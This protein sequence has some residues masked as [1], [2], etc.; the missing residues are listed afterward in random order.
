[1]YEMPKFNYRLNDLEPYI[2]YRT[3]NMQEQLM[4]NYLD[5][6]NRLL[7]KNNYDFKYSVDDLINHI[8]DFYI[9][10][11]DDILF[12][13][14]G[15]LNHKNYF[16]SISPYNK[17]VLNNE[18]GNAIN[19]KYKTFS[20]FKNIFTTTALNLV[21][22]GYTHLVIDNN[23]NLNIINTINEDTPYEYNLIPLITLDLWEHAYILNNGLNKR[24]YINTFF[25][26]ID[27]NKINDRYKNI[28]N[29][30]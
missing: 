8:D 7:I 17:N 14:G 3:L 20:N 30:K 1:M 15:Y 2:D 25:N 5:E 22:N 21:G 18:I 10:D 23:N 4:N 28:V 26:I 29:K 12:N 19:N 13:L 27:F 11:R 9:E 24:N 6:L 16:N